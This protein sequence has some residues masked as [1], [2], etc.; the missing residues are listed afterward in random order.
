MSVTERAPYPALDPVEARGGR[1]VCVLQKLPAKSAG[2]QQGLLCTMVTVILLVSP[3]ATG[4][5]LGQRPS[6]T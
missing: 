4:S 6:S 5:E 3:T 2:H 1:W